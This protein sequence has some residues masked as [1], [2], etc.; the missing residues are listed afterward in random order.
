MRAWIQLFQRIDLP[1]PVDLWQRGRLWVHANWRYFGVSLVAH[2]VI[3]LLLGLLMGTLASGLATPPP[4]FDL[5]ETA[6]PEPDLL[7]FNLDDV[8]LEPSLLN[9]E[10]LTITESPTLTELYYDDSEHFEEAGGGQTDAS[11]DLSFGGLGGFDVTSASLGP[12]VT[13]AG[14]VGES[15]GEGGGFGSGGDGRG[16]AGRG[17]GHRKALVGSG[18]GTI[19]TERAVAAGLSWLARHQNQNG[20]W[21]LTDF[22]YRC[23]D[24]TCTGHGT[25]DADAAATALGLLPFLAAGQTHKS[26][27]PYKKD[28]Q[29]GLTYLLRIQEDDGSLAGKNSQNTLMYSHGL[30]TICLCEA[31]GMT[32]DKRI[33]KAAQAAVNF[34][35]RAQNPTTG[36]WRYLP[37]APGDTSV[38][39]WQVMA[40]KSAQ[41]AGLQVN[42]N[43]FAKAEEYLESVSAGE[44]GG[45]FSYTPAK[46]Y[47]PSMT[48]VALLSHQ[49]MR[50]RP[51]HPAMQ[52]GVAYLLQNTPSNAER[53]LYYWY[54]A[55]QVMHNLS[56]PTWDTWNRT[57]RKVL[58]ESQCREGC[59][60]GSWD[61]DSPAT[62]AWGHAGGRLMMTSLSTLTLEVYYRYL[63]LFKVP[64]DMSAASAAP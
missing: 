49:Y 2:T 39:G 48:A 18:G 64:E 25:A 31:F 36:G 59:A 3:F 17:E 1:A 56:G 35:E 7:H 54:Y 60:N 58:V 44:H 13:G 52:E 6:L 14:G 23:R 46:L 33:G 55:T 26:D 43:V 42:Y 5:V 8:S 21:N 34:I 38:L 32:E 57:M 51:D 28:I 16:F 12:V 50:M 53:D 37:G 61:P 30:A 24:G 41:M 22:S 20:S 45:L 15:P 27:G 4:M 62:D 9:T 40:L 10:T 29:A 63:P 47:T 19:Q 11:D